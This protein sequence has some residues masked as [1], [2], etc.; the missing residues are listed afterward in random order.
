MRLIVGGIISVAMIST[1][2]K[3]RP[4]NWYF[5]SANAAI[6]LN[7]TVMIVATTVMKALFQKYRPKLKRSNSA[8]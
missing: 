4:R 1:K 5:D 6:E 8:V 7:S 2:T 3:V